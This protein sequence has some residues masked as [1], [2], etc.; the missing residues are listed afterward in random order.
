VWLT[1]TEMGTIYLLHF[2]RPYGHAQHYTG[3]TTI[4]PLDWLL[5][6]MAGEPGYW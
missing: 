1:V 3:Y 4:C 2:D 5:T 6:T